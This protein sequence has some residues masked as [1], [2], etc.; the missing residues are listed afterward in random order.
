MRPSIDPKV[1]RMSAS[2]T[3][4]RIFSANIATAVGLTF[5]AVDAVHLFGDTNQLLPSCAH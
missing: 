1:L 4:F 5:S 2:E 3:L